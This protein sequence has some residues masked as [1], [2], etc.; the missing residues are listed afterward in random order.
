L[1][2]RGAADQLEAFLEGHGWSGSWRNGIYSY[3][4]Y[5]STAHEV[6]VVLS[7]S[8]EA[9]LGGP[10]GITTGLSQGD[11]VPGSPSNI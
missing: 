7:G 2:E 3:H 11:A 5:H 1:S 6:L 10:A 9:Q 8:V 4:H